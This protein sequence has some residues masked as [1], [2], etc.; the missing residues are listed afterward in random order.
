MLCPSYGGSCYTDSRKKEAITN[1]RPIGATHWES[2]SVASP[3]PLT[4]KYNRPDSRNEFGRNCHPDGVCYPGSLIA[5]AQVT[6]GTSNQIW[7]TESIEPKFARW[8]VGSE[9]AV[10]GFPRNI[11][12]E[13]DEGCLVPAG[14]HD[15]MNKDP[16]SIYWS[17]HTYLDWD[18][19][20][21]PYDGKDGTHGGK[22]GPGSNHPGVVNH[23]FVDSSAHHLNKD[24]DLTVYM[25][26]IGASAY[27]E[28]SD[29]N[30]NSN[31]R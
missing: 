3:N 30:D 19:D 10:V 7:F 31:H 26:L 18:Y 27:W 13:K 16:N 24:I 6:W 8:T 25:H 15:A 4:P 1:Y 29:T 11:E 20:R 17:Y 5:I 12:F 28:T 21:N 23:G 2:L 14:H 9:A 22:Y